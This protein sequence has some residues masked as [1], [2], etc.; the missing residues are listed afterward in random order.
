MRARPGNC[1]LAD[2]VGSAATRALRSLIQS[3]TWASPR[4]NASP[5]CVH[6][7]GVVV[8]GGAA[9]AA[10]AAGAVGVPEAGSA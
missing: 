9:G 4:G 7:C 3:R 2:W 6:R 10:G 1:T 5:T 8:G